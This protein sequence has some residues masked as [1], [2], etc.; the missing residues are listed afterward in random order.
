[1]TQTTV[2]YAVV[3]SQME[4]PGEIIEQA[5]ESFKKL[6]GLKEIFSNPTI[7]RKKKYEIIKRIF[8][9]EL[10]NFFRYVS[11][12]GDMREVD[13]IFTV[14]QEYMKK[15]NGIL[16]AVLFCV[17]FPEQEQKKQIEMFLKRKY[18]SRKVELE[19][20]QDLSLLGGF[21]LKVG[22]EEYDWSLRGRLKRLKEKMIRR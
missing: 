21:L 22:S 10:Q 6:P 8:P 5:W 1:M 7:D 12:H 20:V 15:Q 9:K 16:K 4:I 18:T 11:D 19:I 17:T 3:L 2:N 13:E 14:Y